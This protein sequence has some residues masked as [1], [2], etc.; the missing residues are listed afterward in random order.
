[1][2][3][4]LRLEHRQQLAG[5]EASPVPNAPNTFD[6]E[7]ERVK[8]RCRWQ[9]RL[10]LAALG[11]AWFDYLKGAE[12]ESYT[13]V[14]HRLQTFAVEERWW[15]SLRQAGDQMGERWRQFPVAVD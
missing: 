9:G 15:L 8:A 11:P 2:Q 14:K 10:A 3:K 7:R 13:E 5:A 4:Q 1:L 12:R 6:A